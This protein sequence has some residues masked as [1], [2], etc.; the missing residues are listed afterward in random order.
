MNARSMVVVGLG[1]IGLGGG[2]GQA[3]APGPRPPLVA[4]EAKKDAPCVVLASKSADIVGVWK[5]YFGSPI[6]PNPSGMAYI[7][8]NPDG[9][10]AIAD[11]PEN[12]RAPFKNWP[13]GTVRF[14]GTRALLTVEAIEGAPAECRTAVHEMRV[15]RLGERPVGLSYAPIEDTCVPRLRDLTMVLPYVGPAN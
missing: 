4:C 7:R 12:T 10:F 14:E 8:Y 6:I 5:Q 9:T 11:T 1:L 13:R 2:L 15:L 3:Q